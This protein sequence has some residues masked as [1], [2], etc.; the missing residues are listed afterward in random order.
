MDYI[1]Q[2][3]KG[4]RDKW[5]VFLTTFLVS[6]LFIFNIIFFL[7]FGD[8]IDVVEEQRKLL[9]LIPSKNFWLAVNL[10]PFVILLVLLF[11]LVKFLHQ[12][13]LLSLTTSRKK[14]DWGRIVFS[15]SLIVIITL[16]S[17]AFSYYSSPELIELQFDPLKFSILFIISILLFPI[18]IGLEEYLFRGYLMQYLGVFLKNK[19]MPLLLTSVL[20]GLMHGANPEVAEMG[21]ITMVF[22]I[23]TG[24]LLGIM[25]LMDNGLE[26][27]LGFHFGNNFLAAILIT[28][29]WSALQTDAIFIY[30]EEEA[31]NTILEIVLPVLIVYPL[32]LFIL[33]KKYRWTNWYDKL[34]GA[35]TP[36]QKEDYKILDNTEIQ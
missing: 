13:S 12:R 5:M 19:W 31:T 34:F 35:V 2:A 22:Y 15:F 6:G 7:F 25:T 30:T 11:L 18:Q 29:S 8:G 10:S 9:E 21:Y 23:G 20:F 24:L 3:F 32:I 14:I 4:K 33:S 26:L 17:F 28:T 16:I 1:Q 36:P 27:A